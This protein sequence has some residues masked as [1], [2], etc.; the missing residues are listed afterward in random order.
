M[1]DCVLIVHDLFFFINAPL[2]G[3]FYKVIETMAA[4]ACRKSR[5]PMNIGSHTDIESAFE[6]FI[7]FL[8]DLFAGQK[9]II[10]SKMKFT[11]KLIERYR[12][13][14][15]EILDKLYASMKTPVFKTDFN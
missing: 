12:L 10:D 14:G 2:N 4:L 3:L 9:V 13:K 8:V 6:R 1:A 7:R 11:F 5:A 15:D